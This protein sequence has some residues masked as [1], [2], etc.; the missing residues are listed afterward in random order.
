MAITA[1]EEAAVRKNC[2]FERLDLP[3]RALLDGAVNLQEPGSYGNL[4]RVDDLPEVKP[5]TN[6]HCTLDKV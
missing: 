3:L 6:F 1:M 2:T 5:H 4:V